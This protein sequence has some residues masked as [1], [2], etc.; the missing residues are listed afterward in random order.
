MQNSNS[1]NTFS[2]QKEKN[3]KSADSCFA[4]CS[5]FLFHFITLLALL[6]GKS[7]GLGSSFGFSALC[8]L[9]AFLSHLGQTL[10]ICG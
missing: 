9:L 4:L 2:P 3:T 5:L 7:S 10:Q 8:C 1:N 6:R